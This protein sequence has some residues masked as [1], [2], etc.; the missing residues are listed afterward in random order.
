MDFA[1]FEKDAVEPKIEEV[2]NFLSRIYDIV[3]EEQAY[4]FDP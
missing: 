1:V 3:W 2:R 4:L